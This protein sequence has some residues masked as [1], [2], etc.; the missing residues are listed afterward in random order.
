MNEKNL[1]N[2]DY[3]IPIPNDFCSCGAQRVFFMDTLLCPN[4]E[5]LVLADLQWCK[6]YIEK[7]K[8]K[9]KI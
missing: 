9:M 2:K 7:N 1:V 5:P 8:E 3:P 6:K 4:C